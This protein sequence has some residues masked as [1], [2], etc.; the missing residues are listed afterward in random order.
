MMLELSPLLTR[1]IE[2][3]VPGFEFS[4]G[5]GLTLTLSHGASAAAATVC[6]AGSPG[7]SHTIMATITAMIGAITARN[8]LE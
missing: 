2:G 8:V 4:Q 7:A 5:M 6:T 3:F 1:E